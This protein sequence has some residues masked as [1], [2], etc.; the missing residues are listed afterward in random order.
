MM[1]ALQN[2]D[3][4]EE[5]EKLPLFLAQSRLICGSSFGKKQDEEGYV[6]DGN[7]PKSKGFLQPSTF[8]TAHC[9]LLVG[10]QHFSLDCDQHVKIIIK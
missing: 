4:V 7:G 1:G 10:E 5:K 2:F 6:C 9:N 8:Q 3:N